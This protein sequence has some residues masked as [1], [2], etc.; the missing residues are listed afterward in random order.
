MN[1]NDK[2]ATA[3]P[4]HGPSGQ[5]FERGLTKREEIAK[6]ALNG[7]LAGRN[8][9]ERQM[10]PGDTH[11]ADVAKACVRYADALLAALAEKTL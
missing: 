8:N 4:C 3:F 6:V 5:V 9:S 11:H 7:Y 2:N 1:T 10:P